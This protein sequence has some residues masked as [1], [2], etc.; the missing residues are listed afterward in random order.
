MKKKVIATLLISTL[1]TS[2]FAGCGSEYQQAYDDFQKQV[3]EQAAEMQKEIDKQ[4]AEITNSSSSE[5]TAD[6]PDDNVGNI[7]ASQAD[8]PAP[9]TVEDNQEQ[10]E[11]PK[12]VNDISA[13]FYET[14]RNDSTGNWRLAVIYDGSDLNSYVG[15][16][17][18]AYVKDDSEVFGIVNLGLKTS[19][20]VSRVMDN[21][22]DVSV[23]EYQD[24]EE[25]DANLL[26]S[27]EE[28]SHYWIDMETGEIDTLEE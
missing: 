2:V 27:G 16:F 21:W 13:T 23:M 19:T 17:Y 24:G 10:T 5:Q 9:D 25:H 15:D 18:K 4:V 28:L 3:D 7:E 6:A 11:Y 1:A 12:E 14:V 20:R 22:L 8:E 26:F